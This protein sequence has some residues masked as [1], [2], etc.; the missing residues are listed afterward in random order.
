MSVNSISVCVNHID[1]LNLPAEVVE[2]GGLVGSAESDAGFDVALQDKLQNQEWAWYLLYE[3]AGWSNHALIARILPF[4]DRDRLRN[5]GLAPY[6][7]TI[8]VNVC[9]NS[10]SRFSKRVFL[11]VRQLVEAGADVN[12]ASSESLNDLPAQATP[13]WVALHKTRDLAI[14]KFLLLRG[15]VLHPKA[16]DAGDQTLLTQAQQ[17]VAALRQQLG[18]AI[19]EATDL[20]P[21]LCAI[22]SEYVD[23]MPPEE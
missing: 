22:A 12:C 2:M 1:C 16:L 23:E 21:P 8:L 17:E 6:G 5:T 14:V 11:A 4:V 13:L 15:A 3:A 9:R 18:A 19:G 10:L 7:F 20:L